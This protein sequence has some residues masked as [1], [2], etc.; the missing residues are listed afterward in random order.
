MFK[1]ILSLNV[2]FCFFL[3]TLGPLPKA[4]ADTVLGLPAPGTMVNLSSAYEPV[5][6]K[7]LTVHKDNPF[8]FDFIVDVGQDKMSD[9][10]LKKEGEK[11]IKYFL[12]SL[13]IPDK[14]VWV[15]L[16]PYEKNK[17][18]PEALGQTDMGRDLLEQDYILKQI[19]ASLIYPEKEL[20]K[21]FWD[22]VY[23]KAQQMY[24][25]T[26][27][28]VD[29][30]NKV[31][32]MADRA[33]VFERNQTAFVVDSHLKVMLEED[34][35]ALQKHVSLRGAEGDVA[36]S[37]GTTKDTHALASQ[38]VRAIILPE[39]EKE[40]NQGQN[41]ANLRQIFN[42]IILSSWYKRNLKE[43]LLNQVYADKAKVKGI[44]L[45]DPTVKQQIYDQYLKA[46]KK[47]VFN[48]IKED[49]NAAGATIPRKY[50]S[51]GITNLQINPAMT[52]DAAA[53]ANALPSDRAM[54]SFQ[55]GLQTLG[56]LL[57]ERTAKH[58][59][60]RVGLTLN[61]LE[62]D[63][64]LIENWLQGRSIDVLYNGKRL[65]S[66]KVLRR[67]VGVNTSKRFDYKVVWDVDTAYISITDAAMNSLTEP[68]MNTLT[69]PDFKLSERTL[70]TSEYYSPK[71]QAEIFLYYI[72]EWDV[73][74]FYYSPFSS[75][76]KDEKWIMTLRGNY[77]RGPVKG[78]REKDIAKIIQTYFMT[79]T[80]KKAPVVNGSWWESL[81]QDLRREL[82]TTMEQFKEWQGLDYGKRPTAYFN[83]I[84]RVTNPPVGDRVAVILG[85]VMAILAARMWLN[86]A[87]DVT[88]FK[89]TQRYSVHFFD[90]FWG[91]FSYAFR[92][93]QTGRGIVL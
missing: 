10:P 31:W 11:L 93:S 12:A 15:N 55:T 30:F 60:A 78:E 87:E 65:S 81:P 59:Q 1:R 88:Y 44:N 29:T 57:S 39:L 20:G 67:F 40:V 82:N 42:S 9:E 91:R 41:F 85:R 22:K 34:Y 63:F 52:T 83:L 79:G 8:L 17:M 70:N 45:N 16:S 76:I 5:I 75:Y 49:V 3:T 54:M 92:G 61:E 72:P 71:T 4:Y 58:T 27:V 86:D 50:F 23:T 26:Q 80:V 18:I 37:K 90:Y 14:D 7:G 69:D 19:T 48:Y 51:G 25:T 6:I 33:E 66:L 13:A 46:Y 56:T 47:G 36:I 84:S 32:I 62:K 74:S 35:L 43:A 68:L 53:L 21:K 38:I 24:G 89:N 28:P 77:V 2:I 73:T 64:G